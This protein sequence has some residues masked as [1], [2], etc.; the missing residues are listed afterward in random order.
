MATL[1]SVADHY[2]R[3]QKISASGLR[4]ARR[5]RTS[6]LARLTAGVAAFQILAAQDAKDSFGGILSEQDIDADALGATN[7][8]ALAGFT[9]SG[10][11]LGA[12][13]DKVR[14][15][16]VPTYAFDRFV[17]TQVQDA[18]RQAIALEM[19]V[20]PTVT[21]YV[22]MLNPPSCSRC[23]ILAGKFYR[24]NEGFLRHPRCDCR[25][26]PSRESLA[27]DLTTDPVTY[28]DALPTAEQ[29]ATF[30]QAGAEILRRT[31]G[32]EQRQ[33]LMGRLTNT[34]WGV[35]T[36]QREDTRNRLMPE[37]ILRRAGDD[38]DALLRELRRHR[39]IK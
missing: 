3:Q 33:Q 26:I 17:L 2:A 27:G 39:Y 13:L 34:R 37:T 18:A 15:P 1:T 24:R 9:S 32:H 28:F 5:L 20:T 31:D 7:P 12:V 38:R 30:T 23:V 29:D 22:R 36:S 14:G 35:R 6:D 25:H 21:G 8:R 19:A 4:L 10:L 16:Q 11:A